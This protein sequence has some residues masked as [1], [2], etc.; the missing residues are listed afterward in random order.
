MAY[1]LDC[2]AINKNNDYKVR[3]I[4]HGKQSRELYTH[5]DDN[6]LNFHHAVPINNS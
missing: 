3:V 2:S 1:Q 4:D 6:W 5:S